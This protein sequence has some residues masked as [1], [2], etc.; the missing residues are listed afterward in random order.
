VVDGVWRPHYGKPWVRLATLYGDAPRVECRVQHL[1]DGI[2]MPEQNTKWTSR[3]VC[4]MSP[5]LRFASRI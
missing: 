1:D 2:K 5:A 3:A 4:F